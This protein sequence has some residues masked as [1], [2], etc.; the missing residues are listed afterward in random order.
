MRSLSSYLIENDV[1]VKHV[2]SRAQWPSEIEPKEF[3]VHK[4]IIDI[5]PYHHMVEVVADKQQRR[6]FYLILGYFMEE[7]GERPVKR[8][9]DIS[10]AFDALCYIYMAQ[11]YFL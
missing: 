5:S 11:Y 2:S 1:F 4:G 8:F 7:C 3:K 6:A 9:E 10:S